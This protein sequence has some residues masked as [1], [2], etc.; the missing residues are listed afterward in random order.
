LEGSARKLTL[1]LSFANPACDQQQVKV[2]AED[3][4]GCFVSTIVNCGDST[5]WTITNDMTRDCGQ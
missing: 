1:P 4:D 2:T 5:T 3:Q